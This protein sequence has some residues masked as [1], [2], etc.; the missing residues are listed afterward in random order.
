[1][2]Q[3][4]GCSTFRALAMDDPQTKTP[5]HMSN[6]I[7]L[8]PDS[9][10]NQIAAGEIVQRPASALKELIENS[11]DAGAKHIEIFV[12]DAGKTALH[13]TDDG[14]GMSSL[15]A[16]MCFAQHATSKIHTHEDLQRISS[17]GFRGEALAAIAAI[18][19]V[20]LKTRQE[21]NEIGTL[22]S[23]EK[24]QVLRQQHVQTQKGSHFAVRNLFFN[25]PARRKFLRSTA[26][27]MR[28]LLQVFLQAALSQPKIAFTL[29]SEGSNSPRKVLYRLPASSLQVRLGTVLG[30]QYTKRI[31]PINIQHPALHIHGYIGKPEAA[32]KKSGEQWLFINAR[33]MR[34]RTLS[35]AIAQAYEA[36]ITPDRYP[37][38]LVFM[39]IDPQQLDVNIHPAKTEVKFE[40]ETTVYSLLQ[41]ATKKALAAHQ[42]GGDINFDLD[43]NF[44]AHMRTTDKKTEVAASVAAHRWQA[45][46]QAA[47]LETEQN[48]SP[49]DFE[50]KIPTF[51]SNSNTAFADKVTETASPSPHPP[52]QTT[53]PP[54]TT[55]ATLIETDNQKENATTDYPFF[56]LQSRYLCKPLRN[57][58]W[59]ID[60]KRAQERILYEQ[61]TTQRANNSAKQHL[62]FSERLPFTVPDLALFEAAQPVLQQA[63]FLYTIEQDTLK[64]EGLPL[65]LSAADLAS[66]F[67]ML[68]QALQQEYKPEI[69]APQKAFWRLS[70]AQLAARQPT[71]RTEEEMQALITALYACEQ[72]NYTPTG[73]RISRYLENDTLQLLLKT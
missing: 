64:V 38:F 29:H 9:L 21:S 17:F 18:S 37:F 52:N 8:L 25:L 42:A 24:G 43:A 3:H 65:G 59:L 56:L 20:E 67:E 47:A 32:K 36:L 62:M 63:G 16:R 12:Q 44:E 10:A 35:H 22:I 4:A 66:T 73:A 61:F 28:H 50:N 14:Q 19:Q 15:D 33:Y 69:Q 70:A 6:I 41:T 2:E 45:L 30:K 71:L 55:P 57:K 31:L 72:P 5:P 51:T 46:Q 39:D 26:T 68:V 53:K 27:E 54:S 34:S 13:V 1:M 23:I 11:L 48:L 60:T 40:D 49:N 58:L 7:E